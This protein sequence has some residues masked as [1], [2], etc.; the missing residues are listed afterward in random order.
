MC[1]LLIVQPCCP[2]LPDSPADDQLFPQPPQLP[3]YTCINANNLHIS[4]MDDR[5]LNDWDAEFTPLLEGTFSMFVLDDTKDEE[6]GENKSDIEKIY[7]AGEK[8]KDARK[9]TKETVDAARD[10]LRSELGRV[11]RE[12]CRH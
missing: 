4:N 11:V 3:R 8:I 6:D 10:D 12:G 9:R 2:A 5:R 1:C 7:L